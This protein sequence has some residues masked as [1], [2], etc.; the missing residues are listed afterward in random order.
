[1]GDLVIIGDSV[2][3]QSRTGAWAVGQGW[4]A[5]VAAAF[6]KTEINYAVPGAKV[7]DMASQWSAAL[8]RNPLPEYALAMVGENDIANGTTLAAFRSTLDAQ[9]SSAVS[10]GASGVKVV[11]MT[12]FIYQ[13]TNYYTT[14]PAFLQAIRE[15]GAKYRVPVI[16]VFRHF[17]EMSICNPS[18]YASM[19]LADVTH[20]SIAGQAEIASLFNLAQN[21]VV[22]GSPASAS[23]PPSGT[24]TNYATPAG[25]IYSSAYPGST[26]GNAFDGDPNTYAIINASGSA[27]AGEWIGNQ[28]ASPVAINKVS[29]RQLSTN[30]ITP[31]CIDYWDGSAWVQAASNVTVATDGS[32]TEIG[33][34][35]P[36]TAK[37]RVRAASSI[38]GPAVSS[39]QRWAPTGIKMSVCS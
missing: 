14:A 13:N 16:D 29:V 32:E 3:A 20:P 39:G 7:V 31:V 9:V 18:L 11:L 35:C 12:P 28:F 36:A 5:I 33:V 1:M 22:C 27:I 25:A 17:A 34:S 10:A 19:F 21:R 30:S 37:C 38:S 2:S 23:P 24:C 15:I 6:G 26:P 4:G 8:A